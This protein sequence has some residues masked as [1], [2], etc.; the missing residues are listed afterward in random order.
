[1]LGAISAL[2]LNR[3]DLNAEQIVQAVSGQG[4]DPATELANELLDRATKGLDDTAAKVL[5]ALLVAD[6]GNDAD[7]AGD[8]INTYETA[9]SLRSEVLQPLRYQVG[10]YKALDPLL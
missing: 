9:H 8:A 2:R 4:S 3:R 10:G 6:W 5:A 1:M 7:R